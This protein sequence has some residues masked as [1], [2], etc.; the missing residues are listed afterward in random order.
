MTSGE[1]NYM[2]SIGYNGSLADKR[3][4]YYN[5]LIAGA[6]PGFAGSAI[7][8]DLGFKG[9]SGDP[10]DWRDGIQPVAGTCWVTKIVLRAPQ[11]ISNLHVEVSTAGATLTASQCLIGLYSAAKAL[12]ATAPDQSAAW[13]SLGVKTAAITPQVVPIGSCYVVLFGNG[14]TMPFFRAG[15]AVAGGAQNGILSAANSRFA[16][17]DTGRTTTLPATLGAFTA[18]GS[19]WAGVS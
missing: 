13:T 9:W 1:F 17:A 3:V 6:Q 19:L 18:Q 10:S 16:T 4:A 15:N 2:Q 12:L 7:P 14:T 8:S 11:T 5:D